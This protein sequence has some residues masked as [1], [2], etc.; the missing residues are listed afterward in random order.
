L[1]ETGGDPNGEK[2]ADALESLGTHVGV[3][4][5]FKFTAED[6]SGLGVDDVAVIRWDGSRF[7]PVK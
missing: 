4:G 1:K 5:V 3:T 7:L 2:V 6:H